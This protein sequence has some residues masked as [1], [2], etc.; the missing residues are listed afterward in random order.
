[1]LQNNKL[2]LG[3][4]VAENIKNK[5]HEDIKELHSYGIIPKLAAVL[6]GDDPASKIY[7]N[8]KHKTFLKYGCSSEIFHLKDNSEEKEIFT[9][10][11]DLNNDNEV[12]GILVQ[13]PLPPHLDANKVISFINPKKD[14]DGLHPLNLGYLMQGNPKFIP[15][16]PLGCI[17][18]L[19]H[20]NIIVN[21]KDVVIIGRSNLVGKPLFSLLS[22]R[23][24]VGNGTVTL[25]HS[26]T[27]NLKMYTKN[28][29]IIIVAVG[30]P[31]MLTEDMIKSNSIIIDVGINRIDDN[32][33]KGYHIV[34]DVDFDNIMHKVSHITPVPGGV[35]PMTI[36]MLLNNTVLSA[37][38]KSGK[39]STVSYL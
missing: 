8:T 13:F 34:D 18:I 26:A 14:V 38:I 33:E 28:A 24:K 39:F 17:E 7:V 6:V 27:K 16:T 35:G 9:L 31:K 10:L 11:D 2:L 37:K 1:M 4:V 29:D 3:K 12:H 23:F 19:K 30:S 15:C 32:S 20:Y 21:S 36:T 5:L 25:C 22:Q